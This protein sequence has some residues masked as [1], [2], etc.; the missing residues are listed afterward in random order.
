MADELLNSQV[1]TKAEKKRLKEERKKIKEEQK[2]QKKEAKQRAKEISQQEAKLSEDEEA[3]GVSVFLVTVVIVVIWIAILCLLIKL[4]VGGFGSGVL[5]P[6]LKDVPVINK[7]LP[8]ESVVTTDDEEA[9]GGYTSLR[10]AVDYIKELELELE[11]AQSASNVNSEEVE[12]L[13]AEVERLQTFED[14]QVEFERIKT[15]FYEEV[16]YA[17]NGPGPEEYQKYYESMDPAT[18]EYLYKQ[19]VQQVE[20]DKEIQDYAQAY[21]EMKPKEAA[22]IFESMTDDLELAAKILDQ[23]SAEDRGKILGVMD[24]EVASRLTKIM[25]PDS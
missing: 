9:Y 5:A 23:M 24:P 4:D 20:E 13:Q 12:Q 16:V 18:A 11:E 14:A 19:V 25:D 3:G 2:A 1:D 22:G 21:A 6:V 10:E 15:E 8:A 7:I 17:E